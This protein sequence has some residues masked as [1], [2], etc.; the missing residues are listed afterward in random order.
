MKIIIRLFLTLTLIAASLKAPAVLEDGGLC[1]C[2]SPW[3]NL[4]AG[5]SP[6]TPPGSPVAGAYSLN[7]YSLAIPAVGDYELKVVSS[8]VLELFRVTSKPPY[9][10]AYTQWS[11]IDTNGSGSIPSSSDF[12]VK[13]NGVTASITSVGFKRRML[14]GPLKT[15]DYRVGNQLYLTIA[16]GI[17]AD[18]S[19]VVSNVSGSLWSGYNYATTNSWT[20]VSPAIHVNQVGY[21]PGFPKKAMVGYYLGS[22]GELTSI[23]STYHLIDVSNNIVFSG[24]LTSRPDAG[25]SYSPTPYQKVYEADFSS[26]NTTGQYR[27]YVP[28]LGC[29][30][31][32]WVNNSVSSA[33]ART[34]ALG[35]YHQRCGANLDLPY[36]RH[37]HNHCH[38]NL[39][40]IPTTETAKSNWVNG[41][42]QGEG[43]LDYI[44][45]VY[46]PY[47]NTNRFN[48][49]GGHH[50]AGDYSKY[51]T[52]VAD[53]IHE[54]MF[55]VD[56]FPGVKNLDNLGIPESGDSISD[57]MQEAKWE[58]DYLA[59]MQDSDG[60]FY[61]LLYP[62][63]SQYEDVIPELGS[64]QHAMPKNT[65][66]TAAAVGALAEIASSPTFKATYPSTAA[67]YLSKAKAGWTF[68]TNAF[69][70]HGYA[71]SY[72]KLMFQ[73]DIFTHVDEVQYAATALFLATSNSYFHNFLKTNCPT[74]YSS[75]NRRWGWWSCF[76]SYGAAFRLYAFATNSGRMIP[77]D[78]DLSYMESCR[79]EL[80][81]AAANNKAWSDSMAYGSSFSTENKG[82]RSG[83]W[84]FSS[85]WALDSAVGY[86][87]DGQASDLD[88]ILKNLNYEM[89]CNPVSV[90]FLTGTGYRRQHEIVHQYAN[91]DDRDMPPTG[92]PLG[93]IQAG[94]SSDYQYPSPEREQMSY[95]SDS[96]ASSPFSYYDRWSDTFNVTT[97]WVV[98]QA[99]KSMAVAAYMAALKSQHTQAWVSVPATISL[100]SNT[101]ILGTTETAIATN[102]Y[103][104]PMD[105]AL[106]V[107]EVDGE[108]TT[109]SSVR[110]LR[111]VTAGTHR[112]ETESLL[113]DGRRLFARTSFTAVD[114]V[115]NNIE[116]YQSASLSNN[117]AVVGW[118]KLDGGNL[119]D[120]RGIS[121][122]VTL[123][124]NAAADSSSF[125]WTNRPTSGAVRVLALGDNVSVSIPNSLLSG[126][127]NISIE[128][129]L[130]IKAYKFPGQGHASL[131]ALAGP[132]SYELNVYGNS[133]DTYP[134]VAGTGHTVV[135]PATMAT[136]VTFGKWQHW[137]LAL[138][139]TGYTFTI[140]G[141]VIGTFANG[142]ELAGWG[143]GGNATLTVG[144]FDGW[145]D[146][147]V[148]KH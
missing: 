78:I 32:F 33:F 46:Y 72:Q 25:Y 53:F 147:V 96:A 69:N 135:A 98:S 89:G 37:Y 122:S 73:G 134:T 146:E 79:N 104:I 19:V 139:S 86:A 94:F 91:N 132:G 18:C 28:T 141:N 27:L 88:V 40:Y 67:S 136:A 145:V 101:V 5:S 68:L 125:I 30:Y 121:S 8:N 45:D 39:A 118:W 85:E 22:L 124:G 143:S 17:P 31:P 42:L 84:F 55:A 108:P 95:P 128:A 71:G 7:N 38:T 99:A 107:W 90:S 34:Y 48:T 102:I 20:N 14:Y 130:F 142:S 75:V 58:A 80:R 52:S 110:T 138:N 115:T 6:P 109:L 59:K 1:D 36:T 100:S 26:F 103:G 77:A 97:E 126:Q 11:F 87:L 49:I 3:A 123:N 106:T 56:S 13:T 74:P 144:D 63:N 113:P 41:I 120:Q 43:D 70:A 2:A 83:G 127:T 140:D 117:A 137:K 23:P 16:G 66:C 105:G 4:V 76:G 116:T 65:A 131:L 82:I 93:N 119:T 61:F 111:P 50:D 9:P 148:I 44:S 54:I 35:I 29:S 60:G 64:G 92:I 51:T 112:I 133:P 15:R 81:V 24:S 12:V 129:M 114:V 47:L 10:S 57:L 21:I 62:T